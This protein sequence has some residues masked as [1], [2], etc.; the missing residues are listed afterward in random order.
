MSAMRPGNSPFNSNGELIWSI[1]WIA[2]ADHNSFVQIGQVNTLIQWHYPSVELFG[3]GVMEPITI[4]FPSSL[5]SP[6]F[7]VMHRAPEH[8]MAGE[9]CN[10]CAARGRLEAA[11]SL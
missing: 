10:S 4:L 3:S 8:W 6:I 7:T 5:V 2:R 11:N 9:M 1:K